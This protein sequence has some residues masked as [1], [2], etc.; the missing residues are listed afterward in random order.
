M[1]VEALKSE[2]IHVHQITEGDFEDWDAYLDGF[3][4]R[5][6]TGSM[7]SNHVFSVSAEEP[8]KMKIREDHEQDPMVVEFRVDYG[9]KVETTKE[10]RERMKNTARATIGFPGLREI[11]QLELSKKWR[12]YVPYPW[13]DIMCPLVS[14][15]VVQRQ[16]AEAKQRRDN[17]KKK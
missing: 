5:F 14:A 11:K 6:P 9:R 7:K 15:E 2:N 12:P 3:Y 4:S 17:K 8:T 16:K 10:R 13:K 1:L